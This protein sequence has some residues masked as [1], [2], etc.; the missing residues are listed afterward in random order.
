[1]L[2]SLMYLNKIKNI[3]GSYG[4]KNGNISGGKIASL[5]RLSL[6]VNS[7]P[8]TSLSNFSLA[9]AQNIKMRDIMNLSFSKRDVYIDVCADHDVPISF[10]LNSFYFFYKDNLETYKLFES[11]RKRLE[12]LF[13]QDMFNEGLDLLDEIDGLFGKSI[14]SLD[15]RMA[16]TKKSRPENNLASLRT[17]VSHRLAHISFLLSQKQNAKS[18]LAFQQQATNHSFGEMRKGTRVK[19][20]EFLSVLLLNKDIDINQN[21]KLALI[22]TQRLYAVDKLIYISKIIREIFLDKKLSLKDKET[23][24]EFVEK[25]A[26]TSNDTRWGNLLRTITKD[27]VSRVNPAIRNIL[28]YYSQGNYDK[29]IELCEEFYQSN[30]SEFSIIDIHVKSL[31]FIGLKNKSTLKLPLNTIRDLLISNLY[32][33]YVSPKNHESA[34]NFFE[35]LNF[36]FSAFECLTSILPAVY[37]TYPFV[38]REKLIKS[39]FM[40]SSSSFFFTPKHAAKLNSTEFGLTNFETNVNEFLLS[41]SR[42]KRKKLES[43]IQRNNEIDKDIAK[44][45]NE[46]EISNEITTAEL[47]Q[48]KCILYIKTGELNELLKLVNKSCYNNPENLILYPISYLAKLL[49][50]GDLYISDG[51]ETIFFSFICFENVNK[52]F[53]DIVGEYLEDYLSEY[54]CTRPSEMLALINKLSPEHV[55]L[56]ENICSQTILS[57]MRKIK[58]TQTML[59]ERIKIIN[60][61]QEKFK[62]SNSKIEKEEK[63]IFQL[64]L[65]SKL[66]STHETNKITIDTKGLFANKK[67]EYEQI[68]QTLIM[69]KSFSQESISDFMLHSDEIAIDDMQDEPVKNS[70]IENVVIKK[71]NAVMHFYGII[72]SQ[73]VAD[74]IMNEDYGL[75]RYL[76][77][78]IRHGVMPNQMRSVFEAENLITEID[79]DGNYKQNTFWIS[80]YK[81]LLND[82]TKTLL[83]NRLNTFSSDVDKLIKSSNSWTVPLTTTEIN[84]TSKNAKGSA[85]IFLIND[86]IISDFTDYIEKTINIDFPSDVNETHVDLFFKTI[87]EYIWLVLD[88][89]FV[90]IKRMLN[91]ILKSDFNAL[92]EN[93]YFDLSVFLDFKQFKELEQSITLSKNRII[94]EIGQI[95]GWFRRPIEEIEQKVYLNDAINTGVYCLKGIFE[96]QEIN[97]EINQK[98]MASELL[99]NKKLLSLTRAI[100][101]V[102]LNCLRHGKYGKNSLISICIALIELKGELF[103]EV[104][105]NNEIT[106]D[107]YREIIQK[108]IIEDVKNYPRIKHS[109]KLV[110]EGGTGLYK[111]YRNLKDGFENFHFEINVEE[112]NFSQRILI[113]KL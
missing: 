111:A 76:S 95:E 11:K 60:F 8:E 96:P 19:Y 7:M 105:V 94:E 51:L 106:Q 43:L 23:I 80:K 58:Q 77:S 108:G 52:E 31:Y 16:L 46:I 37:S 73:F 49:E 87:E 29:T 57:S 48:L 61:L 9:V 35:S 72:Y 101:T 85:F 17:S 81:A 63:D 10:I 25:M 82:Y 70:S 13:S 27:T 69:L 56:F 83:T 93:L 54:G 103:F 50:D 42:Y 12:L 92:C 55:Y 65:L 14:W 110:T 67:G 78:E 45:I 91:E 32:K 44:A 89:C 79:A 34:V 30:P 1:M 39:C 71:P 66:S 99:D 109:K 88:D 107:K 90:T 2:S 3:L 15:C 113:E 5:K 38:N 41:D 102:G 75:V 74:L 97:I 64:L 84:A 98:D 100:V 86:Q 33:L 40:L 26:T 21:N 112:N 18:P 62:V 68:L 6:T 104:S 28:D 47:A 20:A 53:K 24:K 22:F 4:K 59:L 36:N